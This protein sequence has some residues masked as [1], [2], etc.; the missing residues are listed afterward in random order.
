MEQFI[1]ADCNRYGKLLKDLENKFSEGYK[2]T[3]INTL[4]EVYLLLTN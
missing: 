4:T 1:H 3:Y 2:T